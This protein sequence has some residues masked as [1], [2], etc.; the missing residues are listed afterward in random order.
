VGLFDDLIPQNQPPQP[1]GFDDLVPKTTSEPQTSKL[2]AAAL[3]VGS[4]ATAGW[5]PQIAG[6]LAASGVPPEAYLALSPEEH[7]KVSKLVEEIGGPSGAYEKMRDI[8]K[9]AEQQAQKEHPYVYGGSELAGAVLPMALA[10]EASGPG[11]AARLAQGAKIGATYGGIS[12]ASEGTDPLDALEK[13]A[14]GAASGAVGGAGGAGL[15]TIGKAAA[16]YLVKP[17]VSTVRGWINPEVEAARRVAGALTRDYP[18]V[19]AGTTPGLTGT[20]FMAAKAA[21]EPVML[22]DLGGENTRALLRSAANTSPE[23]RAALAGAIQERFAG[24]NERVGAAMRGLVSGGADATTTRAELQAAYDATRVGAY[25]QAYSDGD[26]PL[27][28]PTLETLLGSPAVKSAMKDAVTQGQDRAIV[29]GMG[30]FNPGVS[31]TQDGRLIFNKGPQGVPT[32]PNLQFWDYTYRNLRDAASAAMRAGRTSEGGAL[33]GLAT[34]MRNELDD[35]VL[36]YSNARGVAA[37]FFGANDALEAGSKAARWKGD[38]A[39][40][41]QQMAK[42]KPSERELFREGYVSAMADRVEATPDRNDV[43]IRVLNSPQQ[44]KLSTAILGPQGTNALQAVIN[45]ETVYDAARKAL[46]N[47]TTV[48]QMMEAGLAGGSIG[49]FLSGGDPLKTAEWAGAA[50]GAG[51]GAG[52]SGLVR[53]GVMTGAKTILGY[54]DRNTAGRVAALLASDDPTELMRG[55][56]IASR[57]KRVGDA[58]ADVARRASAVAGSKAIPRITVRPQLPSAV[59]AQPQQQEIPGP[60]QQ[61]NTGGA[62]EQKPEAKSHGGNVD[63]SRSP[64]APHRFHP[65]QIGARQ[66]PDGEWYIRDP[67]RQGK[68]LKVVPRARSA[69]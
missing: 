42:M 56:Q 62:V 26:K 22:A 12:G 19:T 41:V 13:A 38:P 66:A 35:L 67:K 8:T 33:T 52:A 49:A 7:E 46:G 16:D 25:K 1:S 68:F 60:A 11:L 61:Q 20:E 37:N 58:L 50:A 51:A 5:L 53:H 18:Q 47:S 54:V 57:N 34:T 29:Q 43:T 64:V 17:A 63:D 55:L 2:E 30:A 32:Y 59:G 44:R 9:A 10:P 28:S 40:V 21:G 39:I 3:G 4:G 36:S 27:I 65:Q 69:A 6:A 24:Q 48:R 15:E 31:I 23:G 45:R 14:I